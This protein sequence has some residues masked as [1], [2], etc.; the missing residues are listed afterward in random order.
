MLK[1]L[2]KM[3][4]L[5]AH[6]RELGGFSAHGDKNEMLRFLKE[7]GLKIKQIALVHGEEEQILPFR[8]FLHGHG[9]NVVV[10]RAGEIIE[11]PANNNGK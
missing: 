5:K 10:P 4:P 9:Y 3:Y 6:V 2:F 11:I 8:D 1:F 7:S